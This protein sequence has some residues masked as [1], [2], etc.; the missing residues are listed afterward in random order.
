MMTTLEKLKS[1][2][3]TLV[4]RTGKW[5]LQQAGRFQ[6]KHSLVETTPVLTNDSFPWVPELEANWLA[7]KDELEI[8]LE[9][10][11]DIPAFH[12]ISPDQTRISKGNNWKTYTFYAIGSRIDD[13][14]VRCPL[15]AA[16][17]DRLPNLQNAW[18]SILAPRYHIPPHRG[19]TRAFIRCHLALQVPR[20]R[21]KCWIRV[22]N[23]V[24][25]WDEGQCL[26]FDDTYEHEVLNDTDEWRVVLFLDFDRPM[27]RV[28]TWFNRGVL[29]L[30]RSS[31]YFKDPLRNI[32]V[33]NQR[34]KDRGKAPR[35]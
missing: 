13:N 10:P 12:Q 4:H 28:G 33:W 7:I 24:C 26:V 35:D 18:F 27:D 19:P 14:C 23:E 20:E 11:E 25:H 16:L 1:K 17:L 9:H 32:S 15:T 2:R 31:H 5:F 29:G 6:A 34:L 22:D 21:E 3:R 30:I 8:V